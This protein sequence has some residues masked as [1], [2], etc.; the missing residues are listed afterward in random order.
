MQVPVAKCKCK[1]AH[2]HQVSY[3]IAVGLK[4]TQL[5]SSQAFPVLSTVCGCNSS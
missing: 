1:N 3:Q 5:A 2:K 4:A